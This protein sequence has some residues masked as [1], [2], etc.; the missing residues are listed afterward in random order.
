[1]DSVRYLSYHQWRGR[2]QDGDKTTTYHLKLSSNVETL[3]SNVSFIDKLITGYLDAMKAFCDAGS[4]LADAFSAVLKQTPLLEITQQLKQV[5]EE[6]DHV[7]HKSSVHVTNHILA[8]LCDFTSTF[9]SLR[10]AIEAHKRNAQNY[11]SCLEN[12]EILEKDESEVDSKRLKIAKKRFRSADEELSSEEEKL[13]RSFSEVEENRVKML[14]ACFLSLLQVQSQFLMSS[15]ELMSPLG[16]FEEIG[17]YLRDR[18]VTLALKDATSTW[19]SLAQANQGLR[20]G[21]ALSRQDVQSLLSNG[22]Q[23]SEKKQL[24]KRVDNLLKHYKREFERAPTPEA[25]IPAGFH[26]NPRA[27]ELALKGCSSDVEGLAAGGFHEV[28]TPELMELAVLKQIPTLLLRIGAVVHE[29]CP[30]PSKANDN[31]KSKMFCIRDLVTT[32]ATHNDIPLNKENLDMFVLSV[33]YEACSPACSTAAKTAVQLLFGKA[34]LVKVRPGRD[35]AIRVAHVYAKG[36][37]VHVEVSTTWEITAD[38]TLFSSIS[39]DIDLQQEL[40]TVDAVYTAKFSLMDFLEDKDRPLPSIL[41]KRCNQSSSPLTPTKSSV[42]PSHKHNRFR[43][44]LTKATSKIFSRKS[45]QS[46]GSNMAIPQSPDHS[47]STHSAGTGSGSPR[48]EGFRISV[49]TTSTDTSNSR[50]AEMD[51]PSPLPPPRPKHWA[52]K[53]QKANSAVTMTLDEN[54]PAE[55]SERS[56]GDSTDWYHSD[57]KFPLPMFKPT[58]SDSQSQLSLA[59]QQ[60]LDEVIKFLSGTPL[61]PRMVYQDTSSCMTPTD[62]GLG[63]TLSFP[64][65]TQSSSKDSTPLSPQVESTHP[66]PPV[67]TKKRAGGNG[68]AKDTQKVAEPA[69]E[70]EDFPKDD[71]ILKSKEESA[72]W[73]DCQKAGEEFGNKNG[74]S[75]E[76]ETVGTGNDPQAQ[77]EQNQIQETSD[78][79]GTENSI[80][81]NTKAV[82]EKGCGLDGGPVKVTLSPA[83][84]QEEFESRVTISESLRTVWEKAGPKPKPKSR[85]LDSSRPRELYGSQETLYH[86][87]WS[88]AE[89]DSIQAGQDEDAAKSPSEG[90]LPSEGAVKAEVVDLGLKWS[91]GFSHQVWSSSPDMLADMDC[92][93]PHWCRSDE[94]LDRAA[95]GGKNVFSLG[96][97]ITGPELIAAAH[98]AGRGD[99][100]NDRGLRVPGVT[101]TWS[102]EDLREKSPCDPWPQKC[103]SP[104]PLQWNKSSSL[105]ENTV[106]KPDYPRRDLPAQHYSDPFLPSEPWWSQAGPNYPL[107]SHTRYQQQLQR[108]YA[109]DYNYHHGAVPRG[110]PPMGQS[111]FRPVQ[112]SYP[113][114]TRQAHLQVPPHYQVSSGNHHASNPRF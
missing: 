14:G 9:P 102:S 7:A 64:I 71:E 75:T 27:I 4:Q 18:E 106:H 84:D 50:D 70:N 51:E 45:G 61:K 53:I 58:L 16:A 104:P 35:N 113:K 94:T 68:G 8:T 112:P 110:Y 72:N 60:E 29:T 30:S 36:T 31:F 21:E 65:S 28:A 95:G 25:D 41:I 33:L 62:S 17:D 63:S 89:E 80:E 49:I 69:P 97:G 12:L 44:S 74:K 88:L 83:T 105:S 23:E 3:E 91:P 37:F 24:V 20:H 39:N 57:S 67:K 73:K 15:A 54:E 13:Y 10:R 78:D 1:M 77:S 47:S 11:E 19:L 40:G 43:K 66:S 96:L 52:R 82:Q 26:R 22:L 103:S 101:K 81:A 87:C 2:K 100:I 114:P 38:N 111:A 46:K 32:V 108:Q 107:P 79:I 55:Q 42:S 76:N 109:M 99:L 5:V 59:S 48:N 34:N 6:I 93:P 98:K 85:S 86:S 90:Q 56:D 92:V